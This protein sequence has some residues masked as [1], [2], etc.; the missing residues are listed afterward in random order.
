[1]IDIIIQTG[2]L[3]TGV[4]AL[5]LLNNGYKWGSVIGL[6]GQV[7]WFAMAIRNHQWGVLLLCCLYTYSWACGVKR[8]MKD[9]E[10]QEDGK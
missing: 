2:I 6:V 5:W 1:M 10:K 7:F 9:F 8:W 3:L 4:P